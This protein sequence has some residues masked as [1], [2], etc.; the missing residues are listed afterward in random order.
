VQRQLGS[1]FR[2]F[3]TFHVTTEINVW[4]ARLKTKTIASRD[5]RQRLSQRN[6]QYAFLSINPRVFHSINKT[7]CYISHILRVLFA[8]STRVITILLHSRHPRGHP[9][10]IKTGVCPIY[11]VALGHSIK[12]SM[13]R[14]H[15]MHRRA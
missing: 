13:N 15:R 5:T 1:A 6:M 10:V 11:R 12:S 7:Y 9:R 3:G 2:N 8:R 4:I 14:F